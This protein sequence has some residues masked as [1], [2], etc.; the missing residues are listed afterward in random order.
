MLPWIQSPVYWWQVSSPVSRT[1]EK[2][3]NTSTCLCWWRVTSQSLTTSSILANRFLGRFQG[4]SAGIKCWNQA[5]ESIVDETHILTGQVSDSAEANLTTPL[6]PLAAFSF[7]SKNP[8]TSGPIDVTEND[9]IRNIRSDSLG[10]FL[11]ERCGSLT[12][13]FK[14]W[15]EGSLVN[16]ISCHF[17][18]CQH[19]CFYC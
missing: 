15:H 1:E 7:N 5:L 3:P 8:E 18:E 16:D 9:N 14:L 11:K 19:Q 13:S 10:L 12:E 17:S 6:P 2:I 4:S